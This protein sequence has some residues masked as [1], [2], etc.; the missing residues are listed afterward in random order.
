MAF[1]TGLQ[2]HL[3][4]GATHLAHAWAITR[5][6]GEV[7]GF[8]DHDRP[9]EFENIQ[10]HADSGLSSMAL[11]Q[12]TGLS[13]DNSEAIGALTDA[14][15][16]E[17]DIDAG[18]FDAAE[19]RCWLV[20]WS[21]VAQR[22]MLFRGTIG[23][24][25]RAGGAFTAELR[26]LA[27]VLNRPMG[28]VYQNPC[29]AVLGDAA[30]QVDLE[31]P[32]YAMVAAVVGVDGARIVLPEL[33]DFEPGWFTRGRLV[34][35]DGSAVGE[36]AVIKRDLAGGP[37]QIDLWTG[38]RGTLAA[39]DMVRIEAGCDKRFETCRYKFNNLLNYQGF[40]DIPGEDWLKAVPAVTG[41]TTGG[42]R[43]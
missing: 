14:A 5:R 21:D 30:C 33:P 2:Q 24:I 28:R 35:L 15:I 34:V 18:V 22:Q 41:Q 37:R 13:V 4:S 32:G 36:I 1:Q 17:A 20:N 3:N 25:R 40:P 43:R 6:D 38:L 16:R 26:G 31:A 29:G 10:F 12:G 11:S 9:L 42:S 23:E 27:E 19:V 7:L 39:G 8:T